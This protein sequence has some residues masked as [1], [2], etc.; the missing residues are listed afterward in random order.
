M[1]GP[2]SFI[3]ALFFVSA[4]FAQ[5]LS[6]KQETSLWAPANVKV[7]G[8]L[9]EWDG[10][11]KAHNSATDLF[12]T[13]AND[14]KNLYLV[15]H[16]NDALNIFNKITRGGLTIV[17]KSG[18]QT[19]SISYPYYLRKDIP[20]LKQVSPRE[21]YPPG[22]TPER[23]QDSVNKVNNLRLATAGKE[24]A[25]TGFKGL[26]SLISVYN[27]YGIKAAGSFDGKP[28]YTCEM[29]IPLKYLL[30]DQAKNSISFQVIVNGGSNKYI[31]DKAVIFDIVSPD[32]THAP[33]EEV[34]RVENAV[35]V[36]K[37]ARYATT[38]FT[39]EYI[40]AKKP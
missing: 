9:N 37:M 4:A 11:F 1:R 6:N 39:G 2:F 17:F 16:T 30:F 15:F 24:I 31:P 10:T 12:Y 23:F 26:D 13:I 19:Q 29:V 32:G 3:I 34:E 38:D 14:D 21:I 36:S 7:D 20:D 27:E 5:K 25:I 40:L 22:T 35:N 8:K 18:K 28:G 33:K